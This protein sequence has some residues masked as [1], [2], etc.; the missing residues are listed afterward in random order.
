MKHVSERPQRDK[1]ASKASMHQPTMS[2]IVAFISA[3]LIRPGRMSP[4]QRVQQS[5]VT[6]TPPIAAE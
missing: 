3:T 1:G 4:P 2:R 5:G 6:F